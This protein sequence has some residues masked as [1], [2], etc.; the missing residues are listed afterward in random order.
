M[1]AQNFS[2][3]V[4]YLT[5]SDRPEG[6]DVPLLFRIGVSV[7]LVKA[8]DAFIDAG[9]SHTLTL[10]GES[11]NSN[12]FGERWHVGTEYIFAGFLSLRAGYRFNYEE[13]LASFGVG[14]QKEFSG[15]DV[16]VDY[17]YVSYQYLQ[18][19]HRIS[20]SVGF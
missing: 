4:K 11:L 6:Y 18:S 5:V 14:V 17:S 12:D 15:A 16:R 10:A 1:S 19:P 2:K 13:G 9:S 8:G 3:S 7:D 20:V